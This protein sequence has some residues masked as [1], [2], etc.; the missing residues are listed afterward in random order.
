MFVQRLTRAR[1][2]MAADGVDVLLLSVG[3][4]LPYFCGYEAMPLE[5]LTMLVVPRDA[6]ATL[7]VP[8]LEAPRVTERPD[9]FRV[10][11]WTETQDPIRIITDL[12]G[13]A[14]EV[15]VGDHMWSGFLVDLIRGLPEADFRRASTITSPIRSV[16]T[17]EEVERL[18]MAGHA[19]DRIAARLQAGEI[20][21]VGS[22]E[23]QVS[24]ELGRQ[25]LAEGHDRVNFA[26]VAAG[27]NAASPHHEAGDRV[28]RRGE[29]VLCDFGGTMVGDDGVGYCSDVTR[30]VWV[31]ERPEREYLEAYAVLHEAQAASVR[32]ATVGT[33]AEE[34][35]RAGRERIA[36]AGFGSYFIHRTGHGI[37]VEA[38]EDPYIVAGN[39][40]PL[41]AGNAFSIEPGIYMPGRWGMRLEDIVVAT[42][43]G[44]DPLNTVD[45]HLAVVDA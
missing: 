2:R 43:A 24:A 33:P 13:G 14:T 21:L 45:H 28:I 30:C 39:A 18:R 23:A 38:H 31:G 40:T 41:V 15:A 44:P 32:A 19:V 42:D 26:I 4:D 6:E 25:I 22:T 8:A 7:V 9:V 3:A 37:G 1:E 5:R 34:V 35:D 17:P 16:K 36:D 11:P 29:A 10:R 20:P 12:V 27:E